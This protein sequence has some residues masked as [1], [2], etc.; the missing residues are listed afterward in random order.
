MGAALWAGPAS[1]SPCPGVLSSIARSAT[2]EVPAE[3]ADEAGLLPVN[4][5][6]GDP[7]ECRGGMVPHRDPVG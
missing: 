6:P 5:R 3:G 4:Q 1:L 7:D 2:E